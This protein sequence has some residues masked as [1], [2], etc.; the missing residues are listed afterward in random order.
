MARDQACVSRGREMRWWE[1]R[2]APGETGL[3]HP[4]VTQ[5][6]G[7]TREPGSQAGHPVSGLCAPLT[8]PAGPR[9]V[10]VSGRQGLRT[11][12]RLQESG[13]RVE[14][15]QGDRGKSH[16]WKEGC[17]DG[18]RTRRLQSGYLMSPVPLLQGPPFGFS[19]GLSSGAKA[20]APTRL[21]RNRLS[22]CALPQS[23]ASLSLSPTQLESPLGALSPSQLTQKPP[24]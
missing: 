23:Q 3:R 16:I 14:S 8:S 9:P 13:G 10:L 20:W 11:P 12:G 1:T 15:S 17:A 24:K 7:R 18:D 6:A 2:P 19:V 5:L 21:P 22:P 4:S